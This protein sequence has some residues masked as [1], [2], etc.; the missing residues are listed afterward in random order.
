MQPWKKEP[1]I[2]RK[3]SVL[4][5]ALIIALVL[6]ACSFGAAPEPPAGA[7]DQPSATAGPASDNV[8][9][10]FGADSFMRHVY[11]PLISAFNTQHPGISVQFVALDEVYRNGNDNAER[12]RQI[13]SRADTAEADANEQAFQLGLLRDLKPLIDADSSFNRDDFYPSALNSATSSGGAFYKLPQ[14]L[15]V[16]LLFYNK[17]LWAAR[18]VAAP[19]PDWTWQDLQ[20]DAQQLTQKQGSRVTL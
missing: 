1:D 17:D 3:Y 8:T 9:I 20:A 10:T 11:E 2:M 15:D 4:P 14:T 19:T 18:G 7:S 6:S 16:P 12:T 5:L 13:V